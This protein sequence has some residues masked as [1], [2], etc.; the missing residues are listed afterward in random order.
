MCL[1]SRTLNAYADDDDDDDT[2]A[3]DHPLLASFKQAL[4]AWHLDVCRGSLCDKDNIILLF[5]PVYLPMK[6]KIV[7]NSV[8]KRVESVFSQKR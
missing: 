1:D 6:F 8:L 2:I 7:L 5:S 4:L 3:H